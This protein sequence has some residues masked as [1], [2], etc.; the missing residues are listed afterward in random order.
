MS[1]SKKHLKYIVAYPSSYSFIHCGICF[2]NPFILWT[3][4]PMVAK[5]RLQL[6]NPADKIKKL[7][8]H[9]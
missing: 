8:A 3:V 4:L 9:Y 2:I 1:C 6:R 5:G 7:K